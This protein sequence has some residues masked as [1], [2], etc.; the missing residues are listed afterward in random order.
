[1]SVDNI[2]TF[3]E[4]IRATFAQDVRVAFKPIH[5]AYERGEV[6]Y[7]IQCEND[8]AA[9]EASSRINIAFSKA[10]LL[11][12][13]NVAFRAKLTDGGF[14]EFAFNLNTIVIRSGVLSNLR[15]ASKVQTVFESCRDEVGA[16]IGRKANTTVTGVNS[17]L[18][19]IESA[20]ADPWQSR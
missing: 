15:D 18:S 6:V 1:M 19:Q 16:L 13:Q 8:G 12:N 17:V 20:K 11:L 4:I 7:C 14:E 2:S 10:S 3:A 5:R 9:L